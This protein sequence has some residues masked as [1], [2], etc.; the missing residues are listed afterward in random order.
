MAVPK[1]TPGIHENSPT[2]HGFV[3]PNLQLVD[4]FPSGRSQA[5]IELAERRA[6]AR[7]FRDSLPSETRAFL[8]PKNMFRAFAALGLMIGVPMAVVWASSQERVE[9]QS[10]IAGEADPRRPEIIFTNGEAR[11]RVRVSPTGTPSSSV[12]SVIIIDQS[13]P[14]TLGGNHA[15]EGSK[16]M[17]KNAPSH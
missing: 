12:P 1:E 16:G 11:D 5:L 8:T 3:R 17:G 6:K 14:G 2:E 13:R 15:G 10:W 9:E 7:N 4:S